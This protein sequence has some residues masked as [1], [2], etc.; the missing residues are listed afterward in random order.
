MMNRADSSMRLD[1]PPLSRDDVH[2][3][4]AWSGDGEPRTRGGWLSDAEGRRAERFRSER[5]RRRFRFRRSFL[6]GLLASYLRCD[7]CELAFAEGRHGRRTL[8]ARRR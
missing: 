7:P 2:L 4:W 3:W 1:H 5:D 8:D 6:R